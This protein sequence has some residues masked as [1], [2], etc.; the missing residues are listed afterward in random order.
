MSCCQR[1]SSR[2]SRPN[3]A[4]S[5]TDLN[6]VI[7]KFSYLQG[8]RSNTPEDSLIRGNSLNNAVR[9]A[10]TKPITTEIV[11]IDYIDFP[12]LTCRNT[13]SIDAVTIEIVR[14]EK[15]NTAR[16]YPKT[17]ITISANIS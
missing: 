13:Q 10:D 12:V 11:R 5:A 8:I 7:Q 6:R 1:G 9:L 14:I 2:Y 15:S 16:S 17:S 3:I 4:I